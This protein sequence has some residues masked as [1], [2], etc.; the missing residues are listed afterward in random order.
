MRLPLSASRAAS[1]SSSPSIA[2]CGRAAPHSR[3]CMPARD[4][5]TLGVCALVTVRLSSYA[6]PGLGK[7]SPEDSPSNPKSL[8][9]DVAASPR[10]QSPSSGYL[11]SKLCRFMRARTCTIWA[12][13]RL[14]LWARR[15][16]ERLHRILDGRCR[17]L[18]VR[19]DGGKLQA[20]RH[21]KPDLDA[22]PPEEGESRGRAQLVDV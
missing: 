4:N 2:V 14:H 13:T 19:S 22:P 6:H 21:P 5:V 16:S 17:I 3:S 15:L 10:N 8:C 11:A 20:Q 9:L 7:V 1:I 18:I 12:S